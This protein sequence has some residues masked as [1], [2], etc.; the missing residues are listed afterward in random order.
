MTN[1]AVVVIDDDIDTLEYVEILL[2]DAG[3]Q[4]VVSQDGGGAVDLIR[5]EHPMLAILDLR[6]GDRDAGW[7]ILQQL[8]AD[9][10]TE[11]IP[12]ILY[13]GDREFLQARRVALRELGC[14]TLLKPFA[15]DELLTK[16]AAADGTTPSM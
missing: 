5:R 7:T 15:P 9:P 11:Q 16:V 4:P 13:S 2:A 1:L 8:R 6:M 14:D 10:Q 3:Y 12:V